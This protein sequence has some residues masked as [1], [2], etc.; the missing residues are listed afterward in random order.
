MK[1]HLYKG[2]VLLATSLAIFARDSVVVFNE[3]MYHPAGSD[4]LEWVEVYNQ[5]S[6]DVELSGWRID[7]ISYEFPTNTII[8][9]GKYLVI[10]SNPTALQQR[11]GI[12]NVLGPFT[13]KLANEGERLRLLNHNLRVMDELEYEIGDPWPV[14]PDGSGFTMAKKSPNWSS[15]ASENWR[16][17]FE[18][19][20]H[21]GPLIF[22]G[23]TWHNLKS[24]KLQGP[25]IPHS[26]LKYITAAQML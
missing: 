5:M 17:S 18:L 19:A 14:G 26:G 2:L 3:I 25:R 12:T 11:T 16:T 9:G 6:V 13:G 20:V 23:A 8:G 7:G 22:Q 24:R 21:Q 10:A 4:S 15:E 1:L